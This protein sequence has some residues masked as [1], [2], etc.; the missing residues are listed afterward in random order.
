VDVPLDRYYEVV[1]D[2]R[3]AT[4]K[5]ETGVIGVV[6]SSARKIDLHFLLPF[7]TGNKDIGRLKTCTIRAPGP[8]KRIEKKIGEEAFSRK[9]PGRATSSLARPELAKITPPG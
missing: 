2:H 4:S 5:S 1:D 7:V 8:G 6:K 3:V 9:D